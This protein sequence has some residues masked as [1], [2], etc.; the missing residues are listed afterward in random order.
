MPGA[1]GPVDPFAGF[2]AKRDKPF[3]PREKPMG[4][5]EGPGP[6]ATVFG[7]PIIRLRP[8]ETA[9]FFG[10]AVGAGRAGFDQPFAPQTVENV[11]IEV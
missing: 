6:S 1:E 10:N 11:H 3:I 4:G 9:A 2:S 8:H 5:A 7:L